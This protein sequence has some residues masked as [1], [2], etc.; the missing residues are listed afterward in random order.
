MLQRIVWQHVERIKTTES[1]IVTS[2]IVVFDSGVGEA[3]GIFDSAPIETH[4][5]PGGP[6]YGTLLVIFFYDL[7]PL[8]V[9]KTVCSSRK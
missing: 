7:A 8:R 3:N 4:I 5:W 1:C 2:V 6:R 9:R